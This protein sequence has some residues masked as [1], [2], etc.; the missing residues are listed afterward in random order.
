MALRDSHI[1]DLMVCVAK[2]HVCDGLLKFAL[3]AVQCSQPQNG[4]G[5]DKK[6]L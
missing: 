4:P 6:S 5:F 1:V 2:D 3:K